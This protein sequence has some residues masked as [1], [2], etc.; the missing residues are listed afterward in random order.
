M[1][2]RDDTLSPLENG[3]SIDLNNA[4]MVMVEVDWSS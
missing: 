3:A 4:D 1:L 2:D